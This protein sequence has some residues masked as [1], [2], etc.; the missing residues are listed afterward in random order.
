MYDITV[1]LHALLVSGAIILSNI[2]ARHVVED[3]K[4]IEIFA[5]PYMLYVYIFCMAFIGTRDPYVSG[6]VAVLY[7]TARALSTSMGPPN[8]ANIA[9]LAHSARSV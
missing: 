7:A 9:R 6:G 3:L 8:S 4:D 2:G 5:H 1:L